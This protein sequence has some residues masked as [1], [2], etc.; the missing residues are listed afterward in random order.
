METEGR[1]PQVEIKRRIRRSDSGSWQHKVYTHELA[2][3]LNPLAG[4]IEDNV[5]LSSL[6]ARNRMVNKLRPPRRLDALPHFTAE[7]LIAI[8]EIPM[9]PF[10][11]D[12]LTA[13]LNTAQR[14]SIS[15][16]INKFIDIGRERSEHFPDDV[17]QRL[18]SKKTVWDVRESDMSG[19]AFEFLRGMFRKP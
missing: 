12:E 1:P 14:R 7:Q 3:T 16:A 5:L 2:A 13:S 17:Y 4:K 19:R 9:A 6:V 8:G 15:R 18:M 11:W 10:E